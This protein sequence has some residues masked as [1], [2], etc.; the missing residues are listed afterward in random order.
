MEAREGSRE[1]GV[2]SQESRVGSQNRIREFY[3]NKSC[4]RVC[5]GIFF[6]PLVMPFKPFSQK[7]FEISGFDVYLI[8]N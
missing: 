7:N 1:F 5:G 6:L 8:S 3:I 2:G 4:H